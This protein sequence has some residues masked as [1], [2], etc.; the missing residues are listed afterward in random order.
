VKSA[1]LIASERRRWTPVAL[2]LTGEFQCRRGHE[3]GLQ[4]SHGGRLF[5]RRLDGSERAQGRSLSTFN[6]FK[7]IQR[8]G[9]RI[10]WI[11]TR[12]SSSWIP[13]RS[14]RFPYGQFPSDHFPV[15]TK[16]KLGGRVRCRTRLRDHETLQ[17]CS[18][19]PVKPGSKFRSRITGRLSGSQGLRHLSERI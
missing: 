11:L 18:S 13:S 12:G 19:V 6:S 5:E 15:V 1:K 2:I 10:D 8:E 4:D 16:L 3:R 9:V 14:S 7:A 17:D